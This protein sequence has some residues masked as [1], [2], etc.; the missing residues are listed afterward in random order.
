MNREKLMF[1]DIEVFRHDSLVVFKNYS[2][3]ETTALWNDD[4]DR[5]GKIRQ[6]IQ[7]K[8]L[9]GY[10]N[11]S[12]D[13]KILSLM[14]EGKSPEE[15]KRANDAI[16]C[17]ADPGV[18]IYPGIQSLDCMQQLL[19]HPSLKLIEGNLGL[20]I[21]ESSVDFQQEAPLT[22][23]QKEETE[24]YCCYDVA[25]T[26]EVFKLREQSYFDVRESLIDMLP[27]EM[28]EKAFNWN[29]T[30]ISANLLLDN[31]KLIPWS[32]LK[33]PDRWWRQLEEI[34]EEVW[35]MWEG[36]TL[37]N[38]NEKGKLIDAE[39]FGCN[40]SFGV[41]GLHGAPE[42]P[43][44][45]E[46]VVD[47]DASSMYPSIIVHPEIRALSFATET[48]DNIR[49]ERIRIK[50][51]DK[52]RAAALK[53]V[54][55]SVYGLFKS[56]FSALHNPFASATV[57]VYGQI[58]AMYL[59]KKLSDAG[60]QII[61]I[62]TD[63]VVILDNDHPVRPYTEIQ[64]EWQNDFR[65]N[66]EAER[67]DRW[68][69]KDVNNY[70]A[71][72]GD[73]IK[74]KGGDTKKYHGCDPF[75][76]ADARIVHI[77]LVEYLIH[78]TPVEETFKAWIKNPEV[79]MYVLKAGSTF[80][81][82]EDENGNV[83]Q[84]VNRVFAAKAGVPGTVTLQKVRPNGQR[85]SFASV[86]ENMFMWNDD[87]SRIPDFEGIIDTSHYLKIVEDKI[88]QW[89][90][91]KK[92]PTKKKK[93][94]EPEP[95]ETRAEES[96]KIRRKKAQGQV[97][98]ILSHF[99]NVR[100]TRRVW[101]FSCPC[102]DHGSGKGDKTPSGYLVKK[103]DRY[104]VGCHAGCKEADILKAAGL[105]LADL[106]AKEEK[107]DA[108]IRLK[109]EALK[110]E[111]KNPNVEIVDYYDYIDT[112]GRY[113]HTKIRFTVGKSKEK[114]IR[115]IRKIKGGADYLD[116]KNTLHP[117]PVLY[118]MKELIQAIRRGY[119][120]YYVEG[121]KDVKTLKEYGMVATTAGG[122][123]DWKKCRSLASVFTGAKVT[124]LIDND[125]PGRALG[126]EVAKSIKRFCYCWRIIQPSQLPKGDITDYLKGMKGG[127]PEGDIDGFK[128]MLTPERNPWNY[129]EWVFEKLTKND[130]EEVVVEGQLAE[131]V[132]RSADF[133]VSRRATDSRDC[134]FVFD[135]VRYVERNIK[136]LRGI[137][138]KYL[139]ANKRKASIISNAAT[140]IADSLEERRIDR[141]KLEEEQNYIIVQNGVIDLDEFDLDTGEYI[142]QPHSA[143][144]TTLNALDTEYDPDA[145][146]PVF[147][148]YIR[149]LCQDQNGDRDIDSEHMIQE[150]CGLVISNKN[151]MKTK[152]ALVLSSREGNSGKSQLFKVLESLLGVESMVTVSIEEMNRNTNRF[153]LGNIEGKRLI[154]QP[155]GTDVVIRESSV[156]KMLVGGDRIPIEKKGRDNV[157]YSFPGGV[158]IACNGIPTFSDDKGNHTFERLLV[159]PITH[160]IPEDMRDSS[161]A[162]K[163]AKEKPGILNWMLKGLERYLEEEK[164][165]VPERSRAAATE[166][167]IRSDSL[168]QFVLENYVITKDRN[169]VI[170]KTD[171][172]DAYLEWYKESNDDEDMKYAVKRKN[173]KPR[174]ESYGVFADKGRV[175]N[176]SNNY[177]Y[178]GLR[179]K[180]PAELEDS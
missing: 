23:A 53:L 142:L 74:V 49:T 99:K 25:S 129:A 102:P 100:K 22:Q 134:F 174:M 87:V 34:P 43:G 66:L 72:S 154:C 125:D 11:H 166:L 7:D 32:G 61:N 140:L 28:Q 52:V 24:K 31:K 138:Q 79:W 95:V 98:M 122:V 96:P 14:I 6:I 60:Y 62:N 65:M 69:Q 139:P 161:I 46:N 35:V 169:D 94:S 21:I 75:G 141:R 51:T 4:P 13:D 82:V 123:D 1:Y 68:I 30:T 111:R 171:F 160:S 105:T 54:L 153:S 59:C 81:D 157:Y 15:V 85:I 128:D 175:G 146:C 107:P 63:G 116:G 12:Y 143:K 93:S 167:R 106:G 56:K 149:D 64:E 29:T 27:E 40:I 158:I 145:K 177:R 103:S 33:V 179:L 178:L 19:T 112:N 152:Q 71:L 176:L 163:M 57:T 135:G 47:L 84:K 127:K 44:M 180:T 78:N 121:E 151:V 124:I 165:T 119:P 110:Q 88:K 20:S 170:R 58:A 113:V 168:F 132:S 137:V 5:P 150:Y 133:F 120:V 89:T 101:C 70:V 26:I 9:V 38:V 172:D 48:Y 147:E 17:G 83:Q 45:Y 10:N 131:A 37:K 86:P 50:K 118:N 144:Y 136:D 92:K 67:F 76:N 162:D 156:F 16:I 91:P 77:A 73:E 90:T 55:N 39:A 41:G 104:V 42:E 173:I 2:N 115:F 114:H 8:I 108:W 80:K 155:D 148:K 159:L 18:A 36:L 109:T 97:D 164:I 3:T 117:D 126:E 130:I